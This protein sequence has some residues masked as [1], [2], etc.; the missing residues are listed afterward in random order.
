MYFYKNPTETKKFEVSFA[1]SLLTSETIEASGLTLTITNIE[2]D[3]ISTSSLYV[4][5]SLAFSGST[6]TFRLSGGDD[7]SAYRLSVSTGAVT[8][9]GNIYTKTCYLYTTSE[10]ETLVSLDDMKSFLGINTTTNDAVLL[11]ILRSSTDFVTRYTGKT[12]TYDRYEETYYPEETWDRL[13]L[14]NFP[15]KSI[16]SVVVDGVTLDAFTAG[17]P[18]YVL[19]EEGFVRR[20]DGMKFPCGYYP[21]VVTYNAG[22][23]SVPEDILYVVKKMT[24]QDFNS[25]LQEGLLSEALGSY[26]VTYTKSSVLSADSK[27]KEILDKYATRRI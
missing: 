2:T 20:L 19:E 22:Y 11:S 21:I 3:G 18:N 15:V 4:T 23:R 8:T 26:K 14:K 25:R 13:Q 5:S 17:Y 16:T 27:V 10:E 9:S 6:V 24:A 12:F 1:D 7:D